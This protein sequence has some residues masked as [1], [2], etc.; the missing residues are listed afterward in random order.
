MK[1]ILAPSFNLSPFFVN[2]VHQKLILF[3]IS[4][5]KLDHHFVYAHLIVTRFV[6]LVKP[7]VNAKL[8]RKTK[9]VALRRVIMQVLLTI[10]ALDIAQL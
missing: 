8:M 5:V 9:D 6:Y 10:L 7:L 1:N 2:L 3:Y 4:Y